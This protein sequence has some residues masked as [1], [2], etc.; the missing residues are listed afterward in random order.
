MMKFMEEFKT[1]I[2]K[3]NVMDMAVGVVI[4]GAFKGIVDSFVAYIINPL[5]AFVVS[6]GTKAISTVSGKD[7]SSLV[8]T[9][10]VIPGTA[11]NIGGFLS[12]VIN[13][14]IMAFVIFCFEKSVNKIREAAMKK[15]EAVVE[16]APSA[17]T[18]EELLMEIRDLLKENK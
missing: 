12:A 17:P 16:E 18:Q 15:E 13:F 14:L 7:P 1:F 4:G 8:M 3:G 10:W 5:V 9:D 11:I 2:L 6:L